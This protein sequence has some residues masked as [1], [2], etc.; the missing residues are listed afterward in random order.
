M[1]FEIEAVVPDVGPGLIFARQIDEGHW[2]LHENAHLGGV[3]VVNVD[4]PRARDKNGNQRTDL[5]GFSVRSK[6]DLSKL[7]VG[8]IV[9]LEYE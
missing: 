6:S 4:M 9:N 1:R 8:S 3:P 5:F 2:T 7:S